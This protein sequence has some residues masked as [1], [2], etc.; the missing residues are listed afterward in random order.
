MLQFKPGDEPY[1]R[2]TLI[3]LTRVARK[4]LEFRS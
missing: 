2:S 3:T 1:D 4:Q